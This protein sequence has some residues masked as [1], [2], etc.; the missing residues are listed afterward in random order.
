[1]DVYHKVLAKLYEE[2]GGRDSQAVDFKELVKTEGFLGNYEDV[3]QMLSGQGWIAETTKP[4]YVKITHWGVKEAR[5]SSSGA[6]SET[7]E[8]QEIKK[9]VNRLIADTKDFLILL[10]ELSEDA[11]K[12]NFRQV[13][14][15]FGE[16]NEAIGKL[17]ESV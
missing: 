8:L 1:M 15:K 4:N 16:L 7:T 9:N 10:G 6:S 17:K 14:K 3:L 2:T 12:D 11:S 13:E 5:K